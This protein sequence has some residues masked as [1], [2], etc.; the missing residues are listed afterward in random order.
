MGASIT[1]LYAGAEA[2]T[3]D[4]LAA[5]S[6][7]PV[8]TGP[9][10]LAR[11]TEQAKA[12]DATL[13]VVP[14]GTN[15]DL[16]SITQAA[17]ALQWAQRQGA[18][19][20]LGPSL[21]DA[22]RA[23]AELRRHLRA[24]AKDHD[25]V[26]FHAAT[27]DP[28]ADAELLRRVR[29][30]QQFSE[31]LLVEVAFEGSWPSVDTA[32]ERLRLLGATRVA[33]I[34]ADLALGDGDGPGGSRC[35]APHRWPPRQTVRPT[36]LCIWPTTTTMTASPPDCWPITRPVSPTPTAT[37]GTPIHTVTLTHTAITTRR[38]G[39]LMPDTI[40][41]NPRRRITTLRVANTGDRA[42]QVGSHYHFFEVNPALDFDREAA[43]GMHLSIPSGLA[44]RFEP[45][46]TREVELVD[47]GGRR[48]LHGFGG[49]TEGAL[50]DPAVKAAALA[51][52]PEFLAS[53]DALEETR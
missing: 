25:A 50:D 21:I 5:A 14:A 52:L 53:N 6:G 17:Q 42:V 48:V 22:T 44:V 36:P 12:Q 16:T 18:R 34:R 9:R 8:V 40:E 24:A 29:L 19:V 3:P 43:W 35:S 28:F 15:R 2:P 49:V 1:V 11:F 23:I 4:A 47:F 20:V 31:Q 13:V 38:R 41:L 26:L 32:R 33:D 51:K 7:V 39:A 46:D 37:R 27:V 10:D 30:A 45:G